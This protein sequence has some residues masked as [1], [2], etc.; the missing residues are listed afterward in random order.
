MGGRGPRWPW[1]RWPGPTLGVGA[2]ALV[3]GLLLGYAGGHLQA[4]GQAKARPAPSPSRTVTTPALTGVLALTVTG[5]RCAVQLGRTLQLGIEIVNQSG[6]ALALQRVAPVVPLSGLRAV[7]ARW[8]PCGSLPQPV[9]EPSLSLAPGG[10]RWLTVTFRVLARC[11]EPF[12]VLFK[13]SFV[14]SGRTM[15]TEFDS[16]PD[17]GQ[18]RYGNCPT[19]PGS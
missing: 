2:A 12:P 4:T 19:S 6:R 13:V 15:T 9:P 7:A 16:F 10:T 3:V 8:G 1:R 5:D 14:Q 11:P 18:V 17:L